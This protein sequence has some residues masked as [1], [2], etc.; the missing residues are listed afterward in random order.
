MNKILATIALL[1]ASIVCAEEVPLMIRSTGESTLLIPQSIG[2][3]VETNEVGEVTS[4]EVVITAT[5]QIPYKATVVDFEI[6]E[7]VRIIIKT[8]SMPTFDVFTHMSPDA[9][10]AYYGDNAA[11]TIAVLQQVGKII[12]TGDLV[13]TI[14]TLAASLLTTEQE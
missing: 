5:Y 13:T 3:E 4:E 10:E 14:Q 8:Q 2:Y 7:G 9:F 12:P 1:T 11:G 6:T